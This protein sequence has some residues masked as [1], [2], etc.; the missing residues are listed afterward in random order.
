MLLPFSAK[1]KVGIESESGSINATDPSKTVYGVIG[2]SISSIS[3]ATVRI[4]C[5]VTGSDRV[6]VSWFKNNI[7]LVDNPQYVFD[8]K[9]RSIIIPKMDQEYVGNY[10]CKARRATSD[11]WVAASSMLQHVGKMDIQF[12][13]EI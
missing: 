2:N 8:S 13:F 10:T 12:T 5:P 3:G 11:K 9:T 1:P 4:K 7:E 6:A